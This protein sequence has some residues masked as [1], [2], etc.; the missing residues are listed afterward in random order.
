MRYAGLPEDRA[1]FISKGY[2]RGADSLL[3]FIDGIGLHGVR[4]NPIVD[5]CQWQ[6][7]AFFRPYNRL[8]LS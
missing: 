6:D 7:A 5:P 2:E 4:L 1:S 3:F 8:G